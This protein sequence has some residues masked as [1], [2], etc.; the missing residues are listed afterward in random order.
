VRTGKFVGAAICPSSHH[1]SFHHQAAEPTGLLIG[2]YPG[3]AWAQSAALNKSRAMALG[4]IDLF[5][6]FEKVPTW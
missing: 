1:E 4:N 5:P 2:A 3:V 6:H